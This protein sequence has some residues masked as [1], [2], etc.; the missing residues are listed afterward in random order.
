MPP[1]FRERA[2]VHAVARLPGNIFVSM[3]S[4]GQLL[5]HPRW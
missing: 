3:V 5:S 2:P 4:Q 1:G